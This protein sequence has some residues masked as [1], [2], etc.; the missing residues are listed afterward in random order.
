MPIPEITFNIV[1]DVR[2]PGISRFWPDGLSNYV[3]KV[4]HRVLVLEHFMPPI[5]AHNG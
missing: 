5:R 2:E 4:G 1:Y 3:P